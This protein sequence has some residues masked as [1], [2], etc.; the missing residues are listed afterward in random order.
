MPD[1]GIFIPVPARPSSMAKMCLILSMKMALQLIINI[2]WQYLGY[3]VCPSGG[4][5]ESPI[6]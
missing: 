3:Y 6:S 5:P 1:P 4:L 2:L